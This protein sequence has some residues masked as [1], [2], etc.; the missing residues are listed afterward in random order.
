MRSKVLAHASQGVYTL[1]LIKRVPSENRETPTFQ[2]S[3]HTPTPTHTPTTLHTLSTMAPVD[4]GVRIQALACLELG[5]TPAQIEAYLGVSKSAIYRFRRIAIDRGYNPQESKKILLEYLV[6]APRSG[7]PTKVTEAIEASIVSTLSQN[8]TTRSF[9]SEKLGLQFHL[10]ASTIKRTRK[11]KGYRKVKPTIKPGLT[12]A[13]K[14]A[15]FQFALRYQHWTLEDWK[16]V[17]WSD[18][19]SVIL[20][21][22]RGGQRV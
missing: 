13:M 11:R 19:T 6:D 17:I 14:E 1:V 12:D 22:R 7:R 15:R 4:V 16:A 5:Y 8:S 2:T 3:P 18:E 10:S 9:T 21:H 20:R